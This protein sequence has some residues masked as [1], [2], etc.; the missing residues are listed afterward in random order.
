MHIIGIHVAT[1]MHYPS[2]S[3]ITVFFLYVDEVG[4]APDSDRQLEQDPF[5]MSPIL[6]KCSTTVLVAVCLDGVGAEE[7]GPCKMPVASYTRTHNIKYHR[8]T[9]FFVRVYY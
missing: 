8:F 7:H 3:P 9:P 6:L 4:S 1:C 5:P 2:I